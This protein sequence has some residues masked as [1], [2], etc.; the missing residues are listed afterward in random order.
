M[1]IALIS[2]PMLFQ[3]KGGLQ[4]QILETLK[5]LDSNSVDV[6]LFEAS[7]EKLKNYDLIHVFSSINGNHRIVEAAKEQNIPI[8]ITPIIQTT[9][10]TYWFSA[11]ARLLDILVGKLTNWSL[12]TN[13]QEVKSSMTNADHI[14][15]G[16]GEEK[17]A[18]SNAFDVHKEKISIVPIG[19]SEQ[20]YTS[21]PE[22]FRETFNFNKEFVLCAANIST[23]KNQLSIVKALNNVNLDLV[24][25]GGCDKRD[26]DYLDKCLNEGN[27][28]VHYLGNIEHDNPVLASAYA[29]ASVS[30]LVSQGENGPTVAYESLAAGTPVVVT[31]YNGLEMKKND[32]VWRESDP[33][34]VNEITN[35]ILELKDSLATTEMIR[36][37]VRDM[38]WNAI[39]KKLITG[40]KLLL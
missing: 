40:Y 28:R 18:I 13:Y 20:F 34:N 17:W 16:S 3:R 19:V 6:H 23:Y 25:L 32:D 2:Y 24:L 22:L 9:D 1:K 26:S 39:A 37:T 15:A 4:I 21:T 5:A 29:A 10:W 12:R 30:V 31:K 35:A 36:E 8:V 33:Y 11:K 27:G 7:R 14:F 38:S